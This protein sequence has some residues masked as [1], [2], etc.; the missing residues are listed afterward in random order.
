MNASAR[1]S[2]SCR[3]R[4]DRSRWISCSAFVTGLPTSHRWVVELRHPAFFDGGPVHRAADDALA[5]AGLGRVVLDT[6]PLHAAAEITAA[7]LAER[8]NKPWLPI[9]TTVMGDDPVIRVI[10]GDDVDGALDGLA[11]W[12]DSVVEW[13]AA[14]K[15]PYVFVHQP[16]N[17]D[18][19]SLPGAFMLPC[20]NV[21]RLS[22]HCQHRQ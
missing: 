6:R 18:S 12:T 15:R 19:P 22:F 1:S 13:L 11:A 7:A 10:A 4:S 3:P 20:P 21:C 5:T 2:S 9:V 8:R 16:E 14:G 17:L